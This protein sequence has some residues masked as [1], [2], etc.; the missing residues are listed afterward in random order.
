MTVSFTKK[1][2]CKIRCYQQMYEI[3]N[4]DLAAQLKVHERTLHDYDKSADNITIGRLENFL[5]ENHITF[6][7]L[8]NI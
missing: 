7:E 8:I 6:D 3:S 4:A 2:W 1:I 5:R